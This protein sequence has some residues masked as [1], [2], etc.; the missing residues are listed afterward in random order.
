MRSLPLDI[1]WQVEEGLRYG[2]LPLDFLDGNSVIYQCQEPSCLGSMYQ[3]LGNLIFSSFEVYSRVSSVLASFKLSNG[4]SLTVERNNRYHT[5]GH[6]GN[7]LLI[8]WSL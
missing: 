5:L 6:Y 2:K 8:G 3:L 1:G 7:T 4:L